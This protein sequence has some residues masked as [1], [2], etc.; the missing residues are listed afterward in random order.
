[1]YS[2]LCYC[3]DIGG[4]VHPVGNGSPVLFWYRLDQ[5]PQAGALADGDGEAGI[6]PA[7]DGDH[8]V[9]IEAAVG[10]HREL[11]PGPAV[12]NPA[13]RFTQEVGGAAVRCWPGPRAAGT[14]ARRR[15]RRRRPAVGD[16][17]AHRCSRGG[18]RHLLG[19]SV[20][21]R[22]WW[23]PGRWSRGPSPGP[24]PAAQARASNW[25]LTRSNW[26]TWPHRK[27]RRKVPRVEGVLAVKPRTWAVP[28]VAV[29]ASQRGSDQRHYLVAGV[30]PARRIA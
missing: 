30:G 2:R 13:H 18:V 26:R 9:G 25:R 3:Y 6:H 20:A 11:A 4:A 1:M 8:G 23:S 5:V 27:L 14:S 16:S 12:A 29:T 24:A 28:P 7:A 15:F 17:P 21:S 19:Q 10:P 22:R